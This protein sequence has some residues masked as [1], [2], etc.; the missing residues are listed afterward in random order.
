MS[1]SDSIILAARSAGDGE[2]LGFIAGR[3]LSGAE[4][5]HAEAEIYNLGVR[6]EFRRLGVGAHLLGKFIEN[7]GKYR[8]RRIWLDVRRSNLGAISF[9]A[10]HGFATAGGR[11]AF[12]TDPPE[13]ALVMC[14]TSAAGLK[15]TKL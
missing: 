10:R 9:Y 8:V 3:I 2:L 6:Q 4:D 11:I 1:R 14:R 7:A 5:S 12:Y 15:A 13:D